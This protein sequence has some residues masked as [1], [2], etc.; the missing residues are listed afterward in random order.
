MNGSQLIDSTTV[1]L[2]TST[3]NEA[4]E[5]SAHDGLMFWVATK[6][7][8]A[9]EIPLARIL[10]RANHVAGQLLTRGFQPGD[11]AVVMLPTSE[12]WLASFFGVLLAGGAA[13]P[14]GPNL[15]F[16]GMDRY[17][18]TVQAIVRA[19]DARFLLGDGAIEAPDRRNTPSRHRAGA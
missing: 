1:V 2:H 16:G 8:D 18:E 17:A 11:R 5:R 19:A 7:A 10:E 9:E 6:D 3:L 4:L 15:S 14:L 12:G 13:V